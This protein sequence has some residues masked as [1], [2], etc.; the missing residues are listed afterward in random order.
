[1]KPDPIVE[2]VRAARKRVEEAAEKSGLSLGEYL[3]LN[4]DTFG[5][6]EVHRKPQYLR[7]KKTA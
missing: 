7:L 2:E 6:P 3:R 4:Q 5:A 1:M